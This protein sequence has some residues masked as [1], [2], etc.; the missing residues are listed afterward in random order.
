MINWLTKL[1]RKREEIQYTPMERE[2]L[3]RA[4][5]CSDMIESNILTWKDARWFTY[6]LPTHY[7]KSGYYKEEV[8]TVCND[9]HK[10]LYVY[11]LEKGFI[12]NISYEEFTERGMIHF[13]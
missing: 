10:K 12:D 2:M 11:C 4:K 1:L 6:E 7:H 3:D 9:C 8:H 13:K 5:R